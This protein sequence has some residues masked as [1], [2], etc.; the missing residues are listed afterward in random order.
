[1]VGTLLEEA[2]QGEGKMGFQWVV[3]KVQWFVW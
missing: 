3:C 1:M 2:P